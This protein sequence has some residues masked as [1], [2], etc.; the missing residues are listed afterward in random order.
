MFVD[1]TIEKLIQQRND[2]IAKFNDLAI[3]YNTLAAPRPN[4]SP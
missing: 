3:K 2:L 1:A 4:P